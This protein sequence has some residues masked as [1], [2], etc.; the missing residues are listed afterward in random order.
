[1][2]TRAFINRLDTITRDLERVTREANLRAANELYG[3]LLIRIFEKGH[4]TNDAKIGNY[5]KYD[6]YASVNDFARR[7]QFRPNGGKSNNPNNTT[8]YTPKGWAG[9]REANGRQTGFIDL[10]YTGSLK[11]AIK[12]IRDTDDKIRV[13]IVSAEEVRKSYSLEKTLK[14]DIFTPTFEEKAKYLRI[15]EESV[16]KSLDL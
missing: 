4:A 2:N 16:K 15:F 11:I 10:D 12:L 13:S 8:F 1:M 14:K 5:K 7:A 3:D 6:F 9:V